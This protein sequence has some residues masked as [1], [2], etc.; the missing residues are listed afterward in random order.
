MYIPDK[1]PVSFIYKELL[2]VSMWKTIFF[3]IPLPE[4]HPKEISLGMIIIVPALLN[5]PWSQ[6]AR[7][8][9]YLE[10]SERLNVSPGASPAANREGCLWRQHCVSCQFL[11]N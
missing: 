1:G 8:P 9:P 3:Q 7:D 11:E 2:Q 4:I 6:L 10:E 5:S